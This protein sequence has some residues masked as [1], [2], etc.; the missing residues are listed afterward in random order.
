MIRISIDAMGGDIGPEVA[1]AGAAQALTRHPDISY[2]LFGK[3]AVLE[4]LL[5][6]YPKLRIR[7]AWSIARLLLAWRKNRARL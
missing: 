3:S 4:P 2:L 6:T 1:I 7:R 5:A